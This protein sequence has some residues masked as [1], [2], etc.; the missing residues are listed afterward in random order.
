MSAEEEQARTYESFYRFAREM[1]DRADR[2]P[3]WKKPEKVAS[4]W[5]TLQST[6]RREEGGTNKS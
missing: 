4:F 5:E 1:A 3:D 6:H 2:L